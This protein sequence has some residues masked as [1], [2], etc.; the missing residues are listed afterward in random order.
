MAE[1]QD[2]PSEWQYM[3]MDVDVCI[4]LFVHTCVR[5]CICVHACMCA[6]T[7]V[8]SLTSLLLRVVAS[9]FCF[10]VALSRFLNWVTVSAKKQHINVI[11]CYTLT[12]SVHLRCEAYKH[13]KGSWL[14]LKL[15]KQNC[16]HA[17]WSDH[18]EWDQ[19]LRTCCLPL[20]QLKI[21]QA[22]PV[23][24]FLITSFSYAFNAWSAATQASALCRLGLES[25]QMGALA[26]QCP[27]LAL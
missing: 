10:S 26:Q 23:M 27:S 25:S 7:H 15:F 19:A 9:N 14:W 3:C 2:P 16:R 8:C 22:P 20:Q 5:A 4:Y 11:K 24:P 6:C 21:Q 18:T 13:S 17:Y 12:Y 1:S